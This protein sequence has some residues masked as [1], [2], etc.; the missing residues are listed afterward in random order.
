ML[1]TLAASLLIV[2]QQGD[3]PRLVSANTQGGLD[4]RSIMSCWLG[5][6]GSCTRCRPC[7]FKRCAM[8]LQVFRDQEFSSDLRSRAVKRIEDVAML[9][10][11]QMPEDEGP[12]S[13]PIRPDSGPEV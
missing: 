5:W 8:P 11:S 1:T 3:M 2:L 10:S 9:R 6:K 4:G 13:H 12:M 7:L